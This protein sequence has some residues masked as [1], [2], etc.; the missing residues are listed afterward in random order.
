MRRSIA[1]L[2]LSIGIVILIGYAWK[3]KGEV[4]VYET[5]Y[6]QVLKENTSLKEKVQAK[7]NNEETKVKKDTEAFLRAFFTYDTSKGEQ[8]W[9]KIDSYT[10]ELARGKLKPAGEV[11]KPEKTP[12]ETTIVSAIKDVK[13]YYTAVQNGEKANVFSRVW[14]NTTV[15]GV[16]STTQMVLDIEMVYSPEKKKWI[17]GNISIQ[18]PLGEEGYI[19]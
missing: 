3:Q 10:T 15:N 8:G 16:T 18:Q 13:L 7:E 5:K 1:I 12:P 6:K 19:N 14:I 11:K 17:V 2:I 4:K 9:A